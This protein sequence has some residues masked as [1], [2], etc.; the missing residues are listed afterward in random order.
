MNYSTARIL[1]DWQNRQVRNINGIRLYGPGYEYR[2]RYEGGFAA[3]V[4]IER[5]QEGRR[6]FQYFSGIS[7]AHC[8]NA[9]DA[10]EEVKKEIREKGGVVYE[11]KSSY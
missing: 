1:L 3:F 6:K 9:A 7:A 10:L 5:R 2:I 8:M 4:C 11:Q